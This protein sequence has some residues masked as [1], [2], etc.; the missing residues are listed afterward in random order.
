M[1]LSLIFLGLLKHT[2]ESNTLFLPYAL[3]CRHK[4]MNLGVK[5][6]KTDVISTQFELSSLLYMVVQIYVIQPNNWSETS[7]LFVTE[8]RVMPHVKD[9]ETVATSSPN[10][11]KRPAL[12]LRKVCS[13]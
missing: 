13:G 3:I 5:A 9:S 6:L 10:V 2:R 11:L 8:W 7:C 4:K 12:C 1:N